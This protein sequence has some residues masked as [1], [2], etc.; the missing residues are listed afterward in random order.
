[1]QRHYKKI[2]IAFRHGL[3]DWQMVF[4]SDKCEHIRITNKRKIV[5]STYK[6]HGQVLKKTTKAKYLGVTID[7][8]LSWNSHTD[9][10]TKKANQTISFLQRNLSACPRDIKAKATRSSYDLSWSMRLQPGNHLQRPV[11]IELKLYRDPQQ[12]SV[13]MTTA[14]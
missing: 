9:I 4:N 3:K 10:R 12:D 6:I 7:R 14:E 11:S 5:Q 13:R 8:T 1:M 2:L